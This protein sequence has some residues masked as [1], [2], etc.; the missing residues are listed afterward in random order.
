MR[1]LQFTSWFPLSAESIERNAP[2]SPAA[3]EVRVEEGLVEYPSGRSS[4]MVCYFYATE[5][6]RDTLE[7][8]FADE[9]DDP[10]VRGQGPLMFRYIDG[11]D[12]AL[13]HLKKL[14]HKFHTQF[15]DF[16]LFN[17]KDSG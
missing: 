9:I 16:P 15:G 2:Q 1:R 3:V 17:Q 10:G 12:R 13:S 5:N 7:D 4:A 11:S 8:L 6:A 14:L